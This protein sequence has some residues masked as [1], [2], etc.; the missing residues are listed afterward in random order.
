MPRS[1]SSGAILEDGGH[2]LLA[3]HQFT[4]T[5][6]SDPQHA[7]CATFASMDKQHQGVELTGYEQELLCGER[8]EAAQL[9]MRI[10]V[11]VARAAEASRLIEVRSAHVDSCLYHGQASLDFAE[12][13]VSADAQVAVPTTL[14]VGS[15]DLLH[16]GLYRGDAQTARNARRLMD[17]CLDMGCRPTWTCAPY[18]LP[19]RPGV[20][21][22]VAWAESNAIVFANSVLGRG[23]TATA[24]SSTSARL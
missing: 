18:Q 6:C 16:P 1:A 14:N 22:Q 5:L 4:E 19:D 9:A 2:P 13:L 7:F 20:G 21:E 8:G 23:P 3:A 15:L 24:I 12:R 11:G 10:V 17:A